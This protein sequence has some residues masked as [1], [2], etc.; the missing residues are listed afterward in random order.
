[1]RIRFNCGYDSDGKWQCVEESKSQ[2][3]QLA[4][5][6]QGPEAPHVIPDDMPPTQHPCDQQFYTSKAKFRDV[7]RAHGKVEVGN[8]Y[9]AFMGMKPTHEKRPVSESIKDSLQFHQALEGKSEGERREIA[10][11]FCGDPH[12][13]DEICQKN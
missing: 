8:E 11:R 2:P 10:A 9:D 1:M 12:Y 7:T 6:P 5:E 13:A 3:G 4:Q